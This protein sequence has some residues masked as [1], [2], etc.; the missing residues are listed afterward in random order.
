MM[1]DGMLNGGQQKI[2]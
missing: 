2:F 1:D